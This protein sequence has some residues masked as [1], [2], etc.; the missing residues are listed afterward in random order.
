[1][2]LNKRRALGLPE[3]SRLEELLN[4]LSHA[5]GAG[6]AVFGI[7]MLL[8]RAQGALAVTSAAI[9]GAMLI[10]LYTNSSLYH[11]VKVSKAKKYMQIVDHC[12]IFLLIAGTY[13][14]YTLITLK[15]PVGYTILAFVWAAAIAGII[16]NII[17]LK[18][19]AKLSMACYLLMGWSV[20]AAFYWLFK[21]LVLPGIILL[22]VGGVAYT[23]GAVLYGLGKKTPYMHFVWHF[24]VL[25]GSI[26][27]FFSIYFYV[28]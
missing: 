26:L 17:D 5:L 14:P 28:L 1:M 3:Y 20:I 22:L 8:L 19:F 18:R 2:Y 25:A 6:L 27:H 23:I 10:A 24:F 15:G 7:V 13:T 16:L 4:S 12:T 11:G 21:A 9:F